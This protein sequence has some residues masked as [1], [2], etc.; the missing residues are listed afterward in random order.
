MSNIR[1]VRLSRT[2]GSDHFVVFHEDERIGYIHSHYESVTNTDV[3]LERRF[4]DNFIDEILALTADLCETCSNED[5]IYKIF[6]GEEI[7]SGSNIIDHDLM[8]PTKKDLNS[9]EEKISSFKGKHDRAA[10]HLLE[11]ISR[12]YLIKLGF[13]VESG[14]D[15][16]DHSKI[17]IVGK[18]D[19][20]ILP[21]Q[22][23][24]GDIS[25]KEIDLC[26]NKMRDCDEILKSIEGGNKVIYGFIAKR[27]PN[28]SSMLRLYLER[29]FSSN[30]IFI[31]HDEI[32]QC[33][34]KYRHAL[35]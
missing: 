35:S 12:E 16:Q 2:P 17:D 5:F 6:Y 15:K 26:I 34:P 29:K 7:R 4:D 27:F 3:I 13:N 20:V 1:F 23:K 33:I 24:R 19:D 9:L 30:I 14:T 8:P 25:K 10:G 11:S 32:I 31:T 22:V 18:K 28:G 21:V